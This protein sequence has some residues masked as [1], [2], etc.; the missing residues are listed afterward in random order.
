[1]EENSESDSDVN[2]ID[3]GR[4]LFKSKVTNKNLFFRNFG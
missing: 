2:V 3:T 4:D 1:M